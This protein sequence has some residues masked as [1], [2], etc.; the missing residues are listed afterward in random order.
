MVEKNLF[1]SPNSQKNHRIIDHHRNNSE[2]D[3]SKQFKN[4]LSPVKGDL[5]M[6]NFNDTQ[7]GIDPPPNENPRINLNHFKKPVKRK[8]KKLELKNKKSPVKYLVPALGDFNSINDDVAEVE[9]GI[10]CINCQE[11]IPESFIERHSFLCTKLSVSILKSDGL[12]DL[13]NLHIKTQK[14]ENF[15]ENKEKE[16]LYRSSERNIIVVLKRLCRRLMD[17]NKSQ[18]GIATLEV[19][20]SIKSMLENFKGSLSLRIYSERLLTIS[21]EQSQAIQVIEQNE[22]ESKIKEVTE[23]KKQVKIFK[24]RAESL[25]KSIFKNKHPEL[26]LNL[27]LLETINSEFSST[28]SLNSASSFRSTFCDE[29]QGELDTVETENN[30]PSIGDSKDSLQKYFYSQCLALKIK[31]NSKELV[32]L[33]PASKLYEKAIQENIPVDEWVDFIEE[34]LKYPER[35]V[36]AQSRRSRR[37]QPLNGNKKSF[38]FESIIEEEV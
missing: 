7:D 4:Y 5:S 31:N 9:F 38:T 26:R 12:S 20:K 13:E 21:Q 28:E 11:M 8:I 14:M 37:S 33:V 25:Q 24:E 18:N 19:I 1:L 17:S 35:W 23:L 3:L 27:E 22:I 6:I 30:G 15:L 10:L 16:I 32:K 29:K 36:R 34:E 2:K